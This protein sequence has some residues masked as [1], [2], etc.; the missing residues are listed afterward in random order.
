MIVFYEWTLVENKGCL[1]VKRFCLRCGAPLDNFGKSK[2]HTFFCRLQKSITS[3]EKCIRIPIDK[4]ED[5]DSER[6]TIKR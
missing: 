6:L 3:R 2:D 1:P 4:L 5:N